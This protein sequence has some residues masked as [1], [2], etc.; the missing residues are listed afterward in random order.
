MFLE[1]SA[2]NEL[3][4]SRNENRSDPI[5]IEVLNNINTKYESYNSLTENKY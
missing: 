3:C 5:P 1:V 2:N 4:I